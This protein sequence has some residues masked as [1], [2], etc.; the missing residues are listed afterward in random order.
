M[1]KKIKEYNNVKFVTTLIGEKGKVGNLREM[2]LGMTGKLSI[3]ESEHKDP[4]KKFVIFS[5]NDVFDEAYIKTSL[6][7]IYT[8]DGLLTIKTHEVMNRYTFDISKAV[9]E[10]ENV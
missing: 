3:F 10:S 4:G 6:G 9:V 8:N 1:A 2:M 5:V 7:E